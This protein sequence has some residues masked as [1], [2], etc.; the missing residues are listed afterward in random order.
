[1]TSSPTVPSRDWHAWHDDYDLPG[2]PLAVRLAIVQSHVR[3]A[4][5]A[6]PPGPIRVVSLCAGQGRDL[7]GVV[8]SHNRRE[9]VRALLVEADERNLAAARH[10]LSAV[11]LGAQISVVG[12][13]AAVTDHYVGHT[14]AHL[15]LACGIFGNITEPD[16]RHTIANLPAFCASGA[17]VVWTRHRRPPDLT[18][19]IRSWFEEAGFEEVGFT[20]PD[21]VP[22]I[23]VGGAC[24]PG[25][26]GVLAPRLRLFRWI[27]D[28]LPPR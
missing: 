15:V 3:Q 13:D 4:L 10:H 22:Y 21:H 5:D 27:G 18:G 2:S 14:P 9:D 23:G 20:G 25:P 12:G 19:S 7:I 8:A 17:T 24:W 26:D 1:V 6:A 28:P 11:G 16:I